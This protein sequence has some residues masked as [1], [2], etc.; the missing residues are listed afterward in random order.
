MVV[1]KLQAGDRSLAQ[2]RASE[3]EIVDIPGAVGGRTPVQSESVVAERR[4]GNARRRGCEGGG[5]RVHGE[6]ADGMNHRVGC[7]PVVGEPGV[8]DGAPAVDMD[9]DSAAISV[10]P[11]ER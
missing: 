6:V 10:V 7:Y 5:Q 11:T 3:G 4:L 8:C 2:I 9:A 1:R